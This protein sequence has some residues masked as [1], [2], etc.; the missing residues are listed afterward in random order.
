[1]NIY[2]APSNE[3][4]YL[5]LMKPPKYTGG[6]YLQAENIHS[7]KCSQHDLKELDQFTLVAHR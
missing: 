2:R 4:V 1:M 3:L 5:R 6:E 7:G